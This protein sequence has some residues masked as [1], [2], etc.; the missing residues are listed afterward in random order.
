MTLVILTVGLN[1]HVSYIIYVYWNVASIGNID[2][3]YV[4][5]FTLSLVG[6]T[7]FTSLFF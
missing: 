2:F 3:T 7:N 5:R 4:E 6:T 1:M